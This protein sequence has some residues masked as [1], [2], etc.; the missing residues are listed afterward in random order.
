MPLQKHLKAK[1]WLQRTTRLR[2]RVEMQWDPTPA[3]HLVPMSLRTGGKSESRQTF[4]DMCGWSCLVVNLWYICGL[5]WIFEQGELRW[6]RS[7]P[8]DVWTRSWPIST[9][10]WSGLPQRAWT[11]MDP[12]LFFFFF[13]KFFLR[14]FWM[15]VPC[16]Q[17]AKQGGLIGDGTIWIMNRSSVRILPLTVM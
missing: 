14:F 16:P 10:R 9:C 12:D 15:S 4:A 7:V 2:S 17:A 3:Q 8:S 13:V 6:H 5:L 11:C 1:S